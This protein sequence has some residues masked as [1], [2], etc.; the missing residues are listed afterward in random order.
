[1]T[2]LKIEIPGGRKMTRILAG[3]I[4]ERQLGAPVGHI[5]VSTIDLG[6]GPIEAFGRLYYKADGSNGTNDLM[7][8]FLRFSNN[9]LVTGGQ[10]SF[11]LAKGNIPQHVH[12]ENYVWVGAGLAGGAGGQN[13]QTNTGNGGADGLK[14]PPDAV[15]NR[16]S[17]TQLIPYEAVL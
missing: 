6:A 13:T 15:D 4:H 11:V 16:P 2:I 3:H 9:P 10:D 1:M 12:T 7:D 14:D 5:F 8:T 17:F